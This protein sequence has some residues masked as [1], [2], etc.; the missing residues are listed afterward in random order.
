MLTPMKPKIYHIV[1][2]D[3]LPSIIADGHIWCD[4]E[5]RERSSSGTIIGING[6]KNRRLSLPLDSHPGLYVG[7]CVPFY[8]CPRSVML[9]LLH[10]GNRDGL[11][12]RGGQEPIVHLEADLHEVVIWANANN[13]RWA[14]TTAN[15]A[16]S[17]FEDYSD[18]AYLDQIDWDAVEAN[19]WAGFGIEPMV[20]SH[21]QAEFLMEHSFS[22]QLVH[23]IGVYSQRIQ[24]YVQAA[25][26]KIVHRPPVEI[27][28]NWYY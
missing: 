20:Q 19:R 16:T 25:L 1:H 3:K 17:Y 7:D 14:F 12:Y 6:I 21:K 27:I 11:S 28:S 10:M 23:R 9:Y 15:A 2:Y 24:T 22:W 26:S 8:F 18:L 4:R 5:A 13:R